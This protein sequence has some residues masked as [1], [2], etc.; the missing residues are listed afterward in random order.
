MKKHFEI[1]RNYRR[2]N[3][4]LLQ[5]ESVFWGEQGMA[6]S[7]AAGCLAANHILQYPKIGVYAGSGA[8]HSWL[9]FAE[10]FDRMGFY[11]VIFLDESQ[12]QKDGLNNLDVFA[13]SGG[14]TFAVAQALGMIGSNRLERFVRDGGVYIGACAGAY[15]P[16]NSS[17]QYLNLFNFVNVKIANLIKSIPKEKAVSE[18]Y[19]SP[20]GCSFI[21][22]PVREEVKLRTNGEAP[23]CSINELLAPLYGGPPM[24]VPQSENVKVLAFYK[25]FTEKTQ[26]FVSQDIAEMTIIGKAAA[27]RTKMGS[28]KFYL[29]GPH[30]EHPS[31]PVANMLVADVMYWDVKNHT[32]KENRNDQNIL[33]LKAEKAMQFLGN[34]KR[35][36]SN[37]RIV[38]LGMEMAPVNWLIGRKIYQPAKIRIF[39]E[40]I[41]VRIKRL[42]KIEQLILKSGEDRQL[43]AY[44]SETTNLLRMIKRKLDKGLDG[45]RLARIVFSNLIIMSKI[46]LNIYF[47]TV[48]T[49]LQN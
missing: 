39:L 40:S 43:I 32:V 33:V 14:D 27:V 31:F 2:V 37:S 20:Y 29:F 15:L 17:K 16:L 48:R 21:F 49:S 9:W 12:I 10:L 23:F 19:C 30:F 34:I 45:F 13:M 4:R 1:F 6:C 5:G 25:S 24:I 8:S 3:E 7:V 41:W 38:A 46:F 44:C 26:F 35:E 47:K 28:G 36:V 11:D 18:K 22:H 42:E